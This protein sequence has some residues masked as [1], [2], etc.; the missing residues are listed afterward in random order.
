MLGRAARDLFGVPLV[1][2]E[3]S[4]SPLV[5]RH[6]VDGEVLTLA[7]AAISVM[8]TPGHTPDSVC[9]VID[10]AVLTGDTLL[11]GGSGRTDFPG[12]DAGAQYDGVTQR[13][14]AL[15]G[16]TVV[17]PGH[18]YRGQTRSTI[19][20]ERAGNPRFAGNDREQYIALM[21]ALGPAVPRARAAG[22]AGQPV[23]LRG[24]GDRARHGRGR[25]RRCPA[26]APASWRGGSLARRRP[27]CST[28]ASPRSS[29]ASSATSRGRCWSRSTRSPA[30]AQAA[31]L[32]RPRGRRGL[33]RRGPQRQRRG[34][35]TEG[36]LRA[37]AQPVGRD[38]AVGP[39]RASGPAL[40]RASSR[41]TMVMAAEHRRSRLSPSGRSGRSP[42]S[43]LR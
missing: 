2:H 16:E 22:A 15:P 37:R 8:H 18:D 24:L 34:N 26:S 29:S 25:W 9:Y 40:T 4:P 41:Q 43:S 19:G 1:M 23:G 30:V 11:I 36:G 38:A 31:R 10:G 14:F 42:P 3:A 39:R 6:V 20:A 28:C 32:P 35:S 13:L 27:C 33:P 17:W 7:G 12:G 5:D 21:G